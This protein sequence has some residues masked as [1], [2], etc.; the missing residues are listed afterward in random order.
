MAIPK[1]VFVEGLP[2]SGKTTTAERMCRRLRS[3]GVDAQWASE[4]TKDHPVFPPGLLTQRRAPDFADQ[5]L[6]AW[7]AFVAD[8]G[9]TTWVLDGAAFQSTVRFMFEE[10]MPYESIRDYW[11][12]FEDVVLPARPTLFY[13]RD[14]DAADR[15]RT[16]TIPVRGQAWFDKVFDYVARTPQGREFRHMGVEGFI[17]FW[18][19]YG[20]LC[21]TLVAQSRMEIS[22]S[23]TIREVLLPQ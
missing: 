13:L 11:R 21:D 1:L 16:I 8:L 7:H 19:R 14:D 20:A 6:A 15:M 3:R 17:A 18:V 5:C 22:S 10:R 4:T 9:P 2:G 12:A 23:Q